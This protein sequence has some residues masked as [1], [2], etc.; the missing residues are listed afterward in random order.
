MSTIT[1]KTPIGPITLTASQGHL[2]SLDFGASPEQNGDPRDNAVLNLVIDQLTRYFEGTLQNF[3]LP[4]SIH[5]TPF[6]MT[7]WHELSKIPYGQTVSY[8]ELA[9]AAGYPHAARAVG[10]AMS[11]NPVAIILPCHRV[12][13]KNGSLVGFGGGLEIKKFL[14]AHEVSHAQN[15]IKFSL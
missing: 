4:L 5:G 6:M 8:G 12:V 7:T 3:E 15:S 2:T 9:A 13:G 1:M 14:L 10:L 11:K